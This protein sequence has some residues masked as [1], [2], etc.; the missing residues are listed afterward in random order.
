MDKGAKE[1]SKLGK[2]GAGGRSERLWG[3]VFVPPNQ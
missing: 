1:L 2:E 3:C